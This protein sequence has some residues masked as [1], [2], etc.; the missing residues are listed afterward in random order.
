MRI[1]PFKSNEHNVIAV[2]ISHPYLECGQ[3]LLDIFFYKHPVH[4]LLM[5]IV[6]IYCIVNGWLI[7]LILA[8]LIMQL[9]INYLHTQK[10]A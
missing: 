5:A 6:Y 1:F 2:M 3:G 9:G 10:S 4:T 8:M 7:A